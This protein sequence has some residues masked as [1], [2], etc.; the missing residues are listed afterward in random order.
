MKKYIIFTII[1]LILAGLLGSFLIII[2]CK[3]IKKSESIKEIESNNLISFED[4]ELGIKF[5]Y[6]KEWGEAFLHT[7]FAF[8]QAKKE[9]IFSNRTDIKF[10]C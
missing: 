9:I 3:S 10:L 7:S 8:T 5:K 4:R 6:P 2:N 1:I